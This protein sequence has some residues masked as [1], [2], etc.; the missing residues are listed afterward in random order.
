MDGDGVFNVNEVHEIPTGQD[1]DAS[2]KYLRWLFNSVVHLLDQN[3]ITKK[4][5]EDLETLIKISLCHMTGRRDCP[6][7]GWILATLA[8]VAVPADAVPDW[9]FYVGYFDDI[10]AVANLKSLL[11]DDIRAFKEWDRNQTPPIPPIK[12]M[13]QEFMQN[14][15]ENR[16]LLMKL[17]RGKFDLLMTRMSQWKV[18]RDANAQANAQ[19]DGGKR[20][21]DN[22]CCSNCVIV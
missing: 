18:E 13:L 17:V 19:A 8:Y 9:L 11:A 6:K 10:F 21:A 16:S 12:E 5:K 2:N 20:D 15:S 1:N 4:F 7:V 22:P 3:K 14:I